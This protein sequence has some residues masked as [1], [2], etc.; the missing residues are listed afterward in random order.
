MGLL[1]S[2][3]FVRDR[4][5]AV[6]TAR[7]RFL[8]T[9]EEHFRGIVADAEAQVAATVSAIDVAMRGIGFL[10]SVEGDGEQFQRAAERFGA[11]EQPGYLMSMV[12]VD[13]VVAAQTTVVPVDLDLRDVVRA[14]PPVGE[15]VEDVI[16]EGDV[17]V[18]RLGLDDAGTWIGLVFDLD[19][20]GLAHAHQ[21]HH[22]EASLVPAS[23]AQGEADGHLDEGHGTGDAHEASGDD[24]AEHDHSGTSAEGTEEAGDHLHGAV[25]HDHADPRFRAM[26]DVDVFG[27]DWTLQV[28]SVEGFIETVDNREVPILIALGVLVS[29]SLALLVAR[30]GQARAAAHRASVMQAARFAVGFEGSPI[31][32]I[33]VDE[34]CLITA[35][36]ASAQVMLADG[37][38]TAVGRHILDYIDPESKPDASKVLDASTGGSDSE[39]VE[40]TE[41]GEVQLN[42]QKEHQLWVQLTASPID[43]ADGASGLLLQ[44]IDVT[45]QRQSRAELRRRALHDQLTGLPN[46]ALLVDRL[47][48]ALA[49]GHRSGRGT[50]ALFI[51]LDRFKQVNDSLGHRAGDDLLMELA[52]R[53]RVAAR[54]ADTVARFG[55]DEFVVLCEDLESVEDAE[56]V[57]QRLHGAMAAPFEVEDQTLDL[58]LSVGI[59]M[60]EPDDDSE[61]VLRDADLAMYEAKAGG[62]NQTVV[63]TGGMR[64][65]LVD[66]LRREQELR[67]AIDNEQ[68][69]AYFQPLHDLERDEIVGF[70]ALVR[71]DHPTDGVLVPADFLQIADR[72]GLLG[73]IDRLVLRQACEQAAQWTSAAGRTLTVAVNA[74]ATSITDVTYPAFVRECLDASGVAPGDLTIEVTEEQIVQLHEATGVVTELRGMGVQVAID[75]FGVGQSSFSQVAALAFDVLKIDRSLVSEIQSGRGGEIIR[76]VIGMAHTL[77]VTTVAEG[78]EAEADLERLRE[79]GSD[80]VQGY[81]IGRPMSA[82][83]AS[84]RI[85]LEVALVDGEGGAV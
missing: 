55:G 68:L 81:V 76:T 85:G 36:N 58:T 2:A 27:S 11:A 3:L 14:A 78:V 66:R 67:A 62:R 19:H 75:D 69:V 59:A 65:A 31:G 51:D 33:E 24:H 39:T 5:I 15:D 45:E 43:R 47:E 80:V 41:A 4:A 79:L 70:E 48:Q 17:A 84:L 30:M 63:F 26:T 44:L 18:T 57:A 28:S 37:G 25:V 71:W 35:V 32:V 56:A 53:L 22:V 12:V 50:A 54:Y 83:Q 77:G 9:S 46:R 49:R 21:G 20:F 40:H 29:I 74:G 64:E 23:V 6:D 38:D 72:L 34:G 61:A 1:A 82:E 8:V 73:E 10:W 52:R 42:G 13:G 16:I 60:A 7:D